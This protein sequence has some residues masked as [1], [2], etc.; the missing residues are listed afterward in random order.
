MHAVFNYIHVHLRVHKTSAIHIYIDQLY[1]GMYMYI[2]YAHAYKSFD[3]YFQELKDKYN[4]QA[5]SRKSTKELHLNTYTT[6]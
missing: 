3:R 2:V 5:T 4:N 6:I 1:L